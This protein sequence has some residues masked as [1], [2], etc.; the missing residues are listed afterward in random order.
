MSCV[1]IW[2]ICAHI[3]FLLSF[4]THFYFSTSKFGTFFHILLFIPKHQAGMVSWEDNW[5]VF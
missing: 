4:V 3:K 5:V 1:C 2:T